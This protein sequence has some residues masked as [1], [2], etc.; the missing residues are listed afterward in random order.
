MLTEVFEMEPSKESGDQKNHEYFKHQ[1][2]TPDLP[3]LRSYMYLLERGI[4]TSCDG[5]NKRK[6]KVVDLVVNVHEMKLA[7][8]CDGKSEDT[9]TLIVELLTIDKGFLPNPVMVLNWSRNLSLFPE[10]TIP[11]ICNYLLCKADEYSA[12]NVKSFKSLTGP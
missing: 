7:K 5:K 10:V 1:T 3:W 9:N 2:P 11:D 4:Q 8:V 12:E 6:A